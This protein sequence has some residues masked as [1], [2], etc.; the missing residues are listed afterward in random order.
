MQE[1]KTETL[2][3]AGNLIEHR[4]IQ[5]VLSGQ[6]SPGE[7]LGEKE[8]GEIFGVSRTRVREA[9]MRLSSRGIVAVSPRRGWFVIEPT[10][11]EARETIEARR[12]V[13]VGFLLMQKSIRPEAIRQLEAHVA[14]QQ[15]AIDEDDFAQRSY[16]LGH[17]HVYLAEALGNSVLAGILEEL[18]TR[19]VLIAALYQPT[20]DAQC[21]CDNHRRLI[22]AMAEG[23]MEE[24]IRIMNEHLTR[25]ERVLNVRSGNKR[26]GQSA[27]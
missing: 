7:R 8:L 6:I 16:L 17:F 14:E 22:S 18:T 25:L 15:K 11:E 5:A 12:A 2:P 24:A 20:E 26:S 4:V 13:E 27:G 23:H 10:V 9:M 19:T 3:V 21:S 1:H